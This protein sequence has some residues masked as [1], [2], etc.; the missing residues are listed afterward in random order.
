MSD[1]KSVVKVEPIK[2]DNRRKSYRYDFTKAYPEE[3]DDEVGEVN[4]AKVTWGGTDGWP[5]YKWEYEGKPP[6]Y[7]SEHGVYA[8]KDSDRYEA[9]RQAYY[10]ISYLDNAGY[11]KGFKRLN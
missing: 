2:H 4:I 5:G 7:I 9:E 6:V 1:R 8:D 11:I 10:A 3:F